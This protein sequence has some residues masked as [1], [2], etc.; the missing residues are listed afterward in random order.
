MVHS[1]RDF[2]KFGLSTGLLASLAPDELLSRSRLDLPYVNDLG[3]QLYTVRDN[4]KEKPSETIAALAS[5]GYKQLELH[6][7]L[8]MN[9]LKSTI[10][11][12][13]LTVSSSHFTSAF[14]TGRWDILERFG[15]SKPENLEFPDLVEIAVKN[16]IAYLVMPMLF[17]E[18]RGGLDHYKELAQKF[19]R[20]GEISNKAGVR[21]CYH[22]HSFEFEPME[23]STP[24]ETILKETQPDLVAIELDVFWTAISGNDPVKFISDN[25]DRIELLHLKDLKKGTPQT[26]KTIE[27]ARNTP[28]VIVEV[29]NGSIDFL[30]ILKTALKAGVK[31]CYVEQDHT[32]GDPLVSVKSSIDYLKGL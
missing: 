26:Y 31:N 12:N 6:N 1:R 23:G 11:S 19:N 29:G 21:F 25:S 27:T 13:G 10:D 16:K 3:V 24:F 9:E 30:S 18:E 5:M 8:L 7:V 28:E 32:P 17:P 20:L 22:N 4:L 2:V 15:A 14:A